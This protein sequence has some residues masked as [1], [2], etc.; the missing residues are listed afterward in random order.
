FQEVWMKLINARQSYVVSAKFTTYLY[1]LAHNHFI[2]Y[3]RKQNIRVVPEKLDETAEVTEEVPD[4]AFN[5]E[6]QLQTEQTID[7]F[8]QTLNSLSQEQREVF[9]LKEETGMSLQEIAET[10]GINY[11][12]AKSRLR[13]AIN[14]LR[15][16]VES[17]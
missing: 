4:T 8:N 12:A 1:K 11:E 2:D 9:L 15:V 6:Q 5:P 10:I 16:V 13:Y 7:R 14:K 17:S 3:Y